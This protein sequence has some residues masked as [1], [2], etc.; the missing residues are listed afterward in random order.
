MPNEAGTKIAEKAKERK[1]ALQKGSSAATKAAKNA[2]EGKDPFS[3]EDI[4]AA[5]LAQLPPEVQELV[6]DAKS[7]QEAFDRVFPKDK[8]GERDFSV[9]GGIRTALDLLDKYGGEDVKK[10]LEA[11]QKALDL[12]AQL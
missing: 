2:I 5:I 3:E 8:D 9:A 4:Q 7:V 11:R 6:A 12:A 1:E 10:I